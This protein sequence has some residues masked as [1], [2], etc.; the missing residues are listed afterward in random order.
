MTT[1]ESASVAMRSTSSAPLR[2]PLATR[3]GVQPRMGAKDTSTIALATTSTSNGQEINEH[4]TIPSNNA[5]NA[6]GGNQASSSR[7]IGTGRRRIT[8]GVKRRRRYQ[9]RAFRFA[10]EDYDPSDGRPN[11]DNNGIRDVEGSRPTKKLVVT[12]DDRLHLRTASPQSDDDESTD[13]SDEDP[14]CME[15]N[16]PTVRFRTS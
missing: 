10:G 3:G 2:R 14:R 11:L 4:G 13:E 15:A 12:R 1:V 6:V 16:D 8:R 9:G 5:P 7:A